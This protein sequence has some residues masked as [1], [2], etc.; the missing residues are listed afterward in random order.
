MPIKSKNAIKYNDLI[1]VLG[2]GSPD[3]IQFRIDLIK[4]LIPEFEDIGA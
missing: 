4:F 1:C 3:L 2:G